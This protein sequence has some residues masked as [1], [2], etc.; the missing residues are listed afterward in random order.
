M[1]ERRLHSL[2][3]WRDP[4]LRGGEQGKGALPLQTKIITNVREKKNPTARQTSSKA[5]LQC[6][7]GSPRARTSPWGVGWSRSGQSWLVSWEQPQLCSP[8]RAQPAVVVPFGGALKPSHPERPGSSP[9][10]FLVPKRPWLG[11]GRHMG[12]VFPGA[13]ESWFLAA[14]QALGARIWPC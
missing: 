7:A 1:E 6:E 14:P 11:K 8:Q 13:K 12:S 9:F 4:G 3:P 2:F 5:G 10:E